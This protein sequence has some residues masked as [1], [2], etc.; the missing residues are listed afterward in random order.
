MSYINY[1]IITSKSYNSKD[2]TNQWYNFS[3]IINKS[4]LNGC[5]YLYNYQSYNEIKHLLYN[6]TG[7]PIETMI[8]FGDLNNGNGNEYFTYGDINH[9]DT[10]QS[11][12]DEMQR[13][14]GLYILVNI[15][16]SPNFQK[17]N[18]AML[19]NDNK[20]KNLQQENKN[21]QNQISNLIYQNTNL[22]NQRKREKKELEKNMQSLRNQYNDLKNE[23]KSKINELMTQNKN[24]EMQKNKEKKELENNIQ[25][26]KQQY[27]NLKNENQSK[28]S[29]LMNQN[30]NL[31]KKQEEEKN[32]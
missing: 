14:G 32:E 25:S 2:S 18:Y 8:E 6:K 29:E 5:L 24:L 22:E 31:K 4:D 27:N 11:H 3:S 12:Y 30:Q 23:N 17:Q 9:Y 20:I 26:L 28:I 1:V 15:Y 10:I 21:N 16:N 7:L 19:E 13:Y